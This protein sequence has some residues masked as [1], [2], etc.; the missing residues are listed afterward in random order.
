MAQSVKSDLEACAP[1]GDH[2]LVGGNA[3]NGS[4]AVS[5]QNFVRA[6]RRIGAI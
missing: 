6:N 4:R 2:V 3:D 5:R 1:G